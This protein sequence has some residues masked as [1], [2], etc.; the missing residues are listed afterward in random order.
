MSHTTATEKGQGRLLERGT[1]M[2]L[3]PGANR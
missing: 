2:E 1:D 3:G